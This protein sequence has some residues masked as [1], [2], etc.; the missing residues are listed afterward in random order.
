[1]KPK[2]ANVYCLIGSLFFAFSCSQPQEEI[3]VT[4][5]FLIPEDSFKMVMYDLHVLEG[6][7]SRNPDK[8][9]S[10]DTLYEKQSM[11]MFEKYSISEERFK[12][13]FD[14]YLAKPEEM[15][16]MYDEILE[17]LTKNQADLSKKVKIDTS[18][19]K[20]EEN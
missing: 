17:E 14:Y 18:K 16:K 2:K 13:S 10:T 7:I 9:K 5:N 8:V 6:F 20:S 12:K 1:M 4:P 19:V 3:E 11:A 15:D